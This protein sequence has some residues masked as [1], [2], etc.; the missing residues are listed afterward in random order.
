M[1]TSDFELSRGEM[2]TIARKV[3]ACYCFT[4]GEGYGKVKKPDCLDISVIKN[5]VNGHEFYVVRSYVTD[6]TGG[7]HKGT[8]TY[9]SKE[10]LLNIDLGKYFLKYLNAEIEELSYN[11]RGLPEGVNA[12]ISKGLLSTETLENYNMK[13]QS[14]KKLLEDHRDGNTFSTV[15]VVD[16][17]ILKNIV[18]SIQTIQ[19]VFT[20]DLDCSKN[21]L[22]VEL[23]NDERY[24]EAYYE[25]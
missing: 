1:F 18:T 13:L 12:L 19:P 7:V 8:L 23:K 24:I 25:V 3:L 16:K 2:N 4:G 10:K 20:I 21:T 6:W 14:I 11:F 5:I 9:E 17:E 15:G 22:T